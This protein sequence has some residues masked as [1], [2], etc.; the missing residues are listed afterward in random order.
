[1]ERPGL[2]RLT[3]RG[4]AWL[5]ADW[6]GMARLTRHGWETKIHNKTNKGEHDDRDSEEVHYGT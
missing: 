1:M 4:E 5:G 6:T 3:R 2:A